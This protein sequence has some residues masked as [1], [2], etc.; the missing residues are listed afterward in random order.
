MWLSASAATYF[1]AGPAD[2]RFPANLS[3]ANISEIS[4]LEEG[5]KH[6]FTTDGWTVEPIE[7]TGYSFVAPTYTGSDTPIEA[8]LTT[9]PFTVEQNGAWLR[10]QAKSVLP[11]FPETY[12][13]VVTETSGG[14]AVTLFSVGEED[15]I[16]HTRL[17]SLDDFVGKEIS[18][19]FVCKSIN[20]YMLAVKEIFAGDFT[21]PEWVIDNKSRRYASISEEA[22]ANGS[23]TNIGA[24]AE[25]VAVVCEVGDEVLSFDIDGVWDTSETIDFSFNLPLSLN[26]Y[27]SY[28]VG[29]KDKEGTVTTL[30]SSDVFASYFERN[31]MVD[32][33]SGMWCN[34]CPDGILELD[35]LKRSFPGNIIEITCHTND[36]FA[37]RRY[38]DNLQFYAI[39][40]MMLNRNHSTAGG[41]SKNFTQEY[42]A[43]TIAEITLPG[44]VTPTNGYLELEAAVR[45]A[46]DIDN[47]G[48][49]YRIGYT[50]TADIFSPENETYYQSNSRTF[51]RYAQYYLLPSTIPST[52]ARFDNV[53]LSEEYTFSGIEGSIPTAI[54]AMESYATSLNVALP[55]LAQNAESAR[56]VTFILD[57]ESG[58]VLNAASASIN[59]TNSIDILPSDNDSNSNSQEPVYYTLQGVKVMNPTK[60]IY[61]VRRGNLTTKEVVR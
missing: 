37:L 35:N 8:W 3:A 49:R 59:V 38:W 51:P 2:N 42:S 15:Y 58:A 43:P 11:G 53:A 5:Y 40:Y 41:S 1:S 9:T 44:T 6:G 33:G 13:V 7:S 16:W 24:P 18:V 28:T 50:V 23:V 46:E 34:N 55:E 57:S 54:V 52:L 48:D 56:I 14:E 32:E 27:T 20:K 30:A 47:S 25:G 19:S 17:A 45:F 31:L 22:T 21:K 29:I 39:P 60:G 61:I 36:P 10:W 26:E 4:P 12:D